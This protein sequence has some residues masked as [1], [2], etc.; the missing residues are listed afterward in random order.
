MLCQLGAAL[1]TFFTAKDAKSAKVFGLLSLRPLRSLLLGMGCSLGRSLVDSLL[2]D[3]AQP[4]NRRRDPG[5]PP[6][7]MNGEPHA[8]RAWPEG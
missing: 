8:L 5:G 3:G 6:I 4:L 7:G 2:E 1:S